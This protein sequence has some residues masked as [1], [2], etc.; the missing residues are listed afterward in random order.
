SPQSRN[1]LRKAV[2]LV[3]SD[4]IVST[5]EYELIHDN[6]LAQVRFLVN[7]AMV[8]V[9][10]S[11]LRTP[12]IAYAKIDS[13]MTDPDMRK[14]MSQ[15]QL[16]NR[17][18]PNVSIDSVVS[19]QLYN[20][21]IQQVNAAIGV[22]QQGERIIDRGDRV[23]PQLYAILTTYTHMLD[24][25]NYTDTRGGYAVFVGQALFVILLF[26]ALYTFL[27]MFRRRIF[28]NLHH[29]SAIMI[30]VMGLYIL[31]NIVAANISSGI[32]LIP[33]A[34][35]PVMLV[36]FFD[37][38]TAQFGLIV[39]T[40]L[41]TSLATSPFEFVYIQTMAGMTAIFTLREL[42]R[43]SQLLQTALA[44]FIVYTLSYV[45]VEL[46][47]SGGLSSITWRLIGYFAINSVLIS[48]AYVLIFIFEKLFGLTSMVTLVELSDINNPV[49]RELSE[50]CPGTFQHSMS[51][52][53][54]AG[55]AARK[56]NA[57]PLIVRAGALYHDIGKIKNPAF[58]TENQHGVNPHNALDPVKS[59]SIII[60]HVT[61]G[62]RMAE[63]EKFPGVI[64]DMIA[65]HHGKGVA[66]YFY[67]T[68]CN[69]HQGE[70]V[71]PTPFTYP[72]PNP[73]T[74]EASL[75][76]MADS[77]EAA[78]RSLKEYS[79]ETISRLVNSIID[80]QIE[81]GLHAESPL[82]FADIKMI[83]EAFIQRLR[84]IYHVRIA[85]PK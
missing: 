70:T 81:A 6:K 32:Y 63:K 45:A 48:F 78:S 57:N 40:L 1:S 73:Q 84:T 17:L 19:R 8:K 37:S 82:S 5:D 75:L 18:S 39:E 76:M 41:C 80:S 30:A 11:K 65:Q 36:V 21:R 10:S 25:R 31:A 51:V 59:A 52:S 62:L 55:D 60:G 14:A 49:L 58:F 9:P 47:Q 69:A 68:Y 29:L 24:S 12:R 43:R 66:K 34:I 64:F 22:I 38:R 46:M 79:T 50:K 85:Y 83:K 4:G 44:V 16:S 2:E 28:D 35:L 15:I 33:F 42:T 27:A 26:A 13:M 53:N 71:D 61:E 54:L 3:Y 77:V 67:T 20:E 72:G 7:N 23:T 56:I 74:R